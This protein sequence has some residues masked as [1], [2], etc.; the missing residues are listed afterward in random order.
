[1]CHPHAFAATAGACLNHHRIA[2]VIG[3]FYRFSGG[4][5]DTN[6][7]RHSADTRSFCEFFGLNLIAHGGNRV[8]WWADKCNFV[9]RKGS[10]KCGLF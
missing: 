1:M 7:P 3:N 5:N 4:L 6:V 10:G 2:D 8:G 9:F